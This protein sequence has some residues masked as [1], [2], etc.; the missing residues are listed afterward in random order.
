MVDGSLGQGI[1]LGRHRDAAYQPE[2]SNTC[3]WNAEKGTG[4][5]WAHV[6]EPFNSALVYV[7]RFCLHTFR[8]AQYVIGASGSLAEATLYHST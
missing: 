6:F 4:R 3:S 5:I 2:P 7:S 8:N 1:L